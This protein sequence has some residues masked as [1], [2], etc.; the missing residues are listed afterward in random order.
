MNHFIKNACNLFKFSHFGFT[1][2]GNKARCNTC[3]WIYDKDEDEEWK[4]L[5]EHEQDH[6]THGNDFVRMVGESKADESEDVFMYD[7]TG[8]SDGVGYWWDFE[9][10][11]DEMK[12]EQLSSILGID[13]YKAWAFMTSAEQERVKNY[14]LNRMMTN[15]AQLMKEI[16]DGWEFS[17]I[18]HGYGGGNMG[19][20]PDVGLLEVGIFS[21]DTGDINGQKSAV[22]GYM[23]QEDVD[24]LL[25]TFRT[26]P[27]IAFRSIGG[28]WIFAGQQGLEY[29]SDTA[30]DD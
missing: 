1:I 29:Q 15:E 24:G 26:D 2:S 20:S 17:V 14:K 16:N 11:I 25:S 18:D 3:Q 4:G 27:A 19:N 12:H 21:P 9:L 7:G 30:R 23:T 13:Q 28:E 10:P 22:Q 8:D 6:K 5:A